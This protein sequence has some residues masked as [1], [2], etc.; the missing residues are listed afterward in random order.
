MV[1]VCFL[2]S[3]CIRFRQDIK[4]TGAFPWAGMIPHHALR[5]TSYVIC[6]S[7]DKNSSGSADFDTCI[8]VSVEMMNRYR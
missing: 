2:G 3:R 1:E 4:G 5:R 8:L 7:T 6:I